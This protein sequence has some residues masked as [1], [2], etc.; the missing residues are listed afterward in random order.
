MELQQELYRLIEAAR[1]LGISRSRLYQGIEAGEIPIVTVCGMRRVPR[2]WL[3]DA[4]AKAMA[5]A[6]SENRAA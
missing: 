3:E 5:S 2:A 6:K 4:V 1:V